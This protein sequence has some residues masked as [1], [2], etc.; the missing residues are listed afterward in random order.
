M[1][2]GEKNLKSRIIHLHDTEAN[3]NL[4][5]EF[6]PK[7]GEIVVYDKDTNFNYE[8]FKI[9]NGITTIINLPFALENEINNLINSIE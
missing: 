1:K 5:T 2:M 7:I 3:W 4:K 8:R 6:I 9:G